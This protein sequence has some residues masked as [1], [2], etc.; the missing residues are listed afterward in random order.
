[1]AYLAGQLVSGSLYQVR[2]SDPL[3]LSGAAIAVIVIA[4]SAIVIPAY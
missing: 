2:A 1:M 4:V 3:I